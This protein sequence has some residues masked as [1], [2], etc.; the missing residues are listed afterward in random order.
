MANSAKY[1]QE[2]FHTITPY[3]YGGNELVDFLK[4]VFA[5]RFIAASRTPMAMCI[6]K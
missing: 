1:I 6:R 4:R 3:L 5:A 2:G